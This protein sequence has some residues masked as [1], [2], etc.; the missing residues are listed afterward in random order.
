MKKIFKTTICL[1]LV[2]ALLL[3]SLASCRN[4]DDNSGANSNTSNNINTSGNR[5]AAT[6]TAAGRYV[7]VD[8]TPPIDGQFL[9]F[10]THDG[11]IVA[12]DNMLRSKYSSTDGGETWTDAPGPWHDSDEFHFIRAAALLP[13]GRLLVFLHN[14]GLVKINPDGS[15]S[16]FPIDRIDEAMAGGEDI[17]VNVSMIEILRDDRVLLSYTIHEFSQVQMGGGAWRDGED[18][19]ENENENDEATPRGMTVGMGGN[20][21][22]MHVALYDLNTG[23][24]VADLPM[25]GASSAAAGSQHFYVLSAMEERIYS[26]DISTGTPTNQT[27][28]SLAA[29][30]EIS[31]GG[32]RMMGMGGGILTLNSYDELLAVHNNTL[33][34]MLADNVNTV[35]DGNSFSFGEPNSSVVNV[36]S[37]ADGST[38]IDILT[39]QQ[40]NRLYRYAWDENATI[41]PERTLTV[42]SL[43]NND[44]VRATITELRRRHPDAYITYEVAL[45]DMGMSASDAIRTLNTRLLSG[46]GPDV[47]ILDGTPVENY[48]GRGMLLD[49]SGALNTSDM[50]SNLLAP[51]I[52]PGGGIYALPMQLRIPALAGDP[53]TIAAVQN[54]DTLVNRVVTGN[55]PAAQDAMSFG[56]MG[57]LQ[58]N[59]RAELHFATLR[60]LF[61][62]MWLANA[63]AIID[64]NQL[65]SAVLMQ[66]FNAI[67]AISD[68]YDLGQPDPMGGMF[69]MVSVFGGAGRPVM[70]PPSL[71]QYVSHSTNMATFNIDNLMIMS[72][73]GNRANTELAIFPGMVPGTWLPSTIVGVS[74][75]TH[76]ADFATEFVNAMLSPD[77]QRIN[78]GEGLPVTQTGVAFQV[79]ELNERQEQMREQLREVGQEPFE[80][81]LDALVRQLETPAVIETTLLEI[82]WESTER[83]GAGAISLEGAVSEVEQNIRNY[84]AERS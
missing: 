2:A 39:G 27:P 65:N 64:D 84:L 62:F 57:G 70:L 12:F 52:Q 10:L 41:S 14:E 36:M 1:V 35:L 75:D 3:T 63:S 21:M 53:Q 60:E 5:Q 18:D 20:R 15:T 44:F 30:D 47:L 49:L 56:G 31:M 67:S 42:W 48:V 54:F 45:S 37:L 76:V 32:F 78:Y 40:T 7:E 81:D 28:V 13:D 9:S 79:Q 8:I 73:L 58:E 51:Y 24:L 46:R 71:V 68:M 6:P 55:R 4:N 82:I 74:A 17:H 83:L 80:F 16:P 69:S 33:L 34:H 19:N 22:D 38:V 72:M 77:I 26:F 66:F 61:D 29:S 11:T 43:T 50:Y 23:T 59:E 25:E